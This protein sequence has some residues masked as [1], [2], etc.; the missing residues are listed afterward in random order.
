MVVLEIAVIFN[1][2]MLHKAKSYAEFKTLDKN[3][4]IPYCP[5]WA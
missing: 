5:T 4:T 3:A 1:G 2:A